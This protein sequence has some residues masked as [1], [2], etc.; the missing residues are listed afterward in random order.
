[1]SFAMMETDIKVR[2]VD[3]QCAALG[4]KKSIGLGLHLAITMYQ[5]C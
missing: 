1:M 3:E 2:K 4:V 5:F